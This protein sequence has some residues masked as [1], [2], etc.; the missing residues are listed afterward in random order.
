MTIFLDTNIVLDLL[1][2]REPHYTNVADLYESSH[3]IQKGLLH[4]QL[5]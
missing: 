3:E 4:L 5:P 1:S 2:K